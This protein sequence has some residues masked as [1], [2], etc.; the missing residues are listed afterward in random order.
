M[1]SVL[2]EAD[3][4]IVC[5]INDLIG[6]GFSKILVMTCDSDVVV[7][8]L[9]FMKVF[10]DVMKDLL[11]LVEF[12]T[13][14]NKRIISINSS[15]LKLGDEICSGLIFYHCF[16]GAVS[17]T[18]FKI[19]KKD[20]FSKWMNFPQKSVLNDTFRKLGRCPTEVEVIGSQVIIRKFVAYVYT[21][22]TDCD[23]DELRFYSFKNCSSSE[24]RTLPP[25]KDALLH[26]IFRCSYQA[27]W[28]WG[29]SLI[30]RDPPPLES[31]GWEIYQGHIRLRWKSLNVQEEL[32]I[33]LSICQCRTNKCT[34]CKCA[35]NLQRCLK[36][37]HCCRN[38]KNV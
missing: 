26:H 3:N 22:K 27:G 35:R 21:K 16:T 19:S 11:L 38:S 24:L 15:Y 32:E 23:L 8:L 5:H 34:A 31:W 13:A 37:C 10:L 12:K 9:G 2:E 6:N 4:L 14:N 18:S 33:A 36:F 20:W 25:T 28:V 17:S 29:N 1:I 7:I 30:Q